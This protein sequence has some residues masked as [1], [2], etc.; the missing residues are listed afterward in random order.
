[1]NYSLNGC[2]PGDNVKV[3]ESL[4]RCQFEATSKPVG[5]STFYNHTYSG[6]TCVL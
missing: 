5:G 4:I 2:T 3:I 6:T 1:M